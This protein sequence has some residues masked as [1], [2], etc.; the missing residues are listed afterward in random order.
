[1]VPDVS[2]PLILS[3]MR[4]VNLVRTSISLTCLAVVSVAG[5]QT[6]SGPGQY[7]QFRNMSGFSGGLFGVTREGVPSMRGAMAIS[8]PIGY[9]L[10]DYHVALGY[11]SQSI[12]RRLRF[13]DS[14]GD[15]ARANGTAQGIIGLRTKF[16]SLAF[17]DMVHSKLGDS[18]LNL[19]FQF[20]SNVPKFGLSVGVQDA[21]STGGAAGQDIPGDNDISRSYWVAATYEFA[22]GIHGTIGKGDRRFKGVFASASANVSPRLKFVAEYDT[23]NIN[24]AVSY[25][26]GP[27]KPFD[28]KYTLNPEDDTR[29][30][31]VFLTFG[32]I[33]TSNV[34]WGVNITF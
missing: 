4:S 14:S 18:V 7:P 32:Y 10:S 12:D 5:A 33:R 23:F 22:P 24:Y 28:P 11:A 30:G 34:F 25:N 15:S 8:T 16:G 2:E 3:G 20:K 19:Q 29:R 27:W 6:L 26:L 9:S 31:D 1:M 17:S 21:F 13:P